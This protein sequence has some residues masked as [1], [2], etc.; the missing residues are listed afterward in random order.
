MRF[1]VLLLAVICALAPA[2]ANADEGHPDWVF[3]GEEHSDSYSPCY[4]AS[5]GYD[6]FP[7]VPADFP[8]EEVAYGE[9]RFYTQGRMF[10]APTVPIRV[11]ATCGEQVAESWTWVGGLCGEDLEPECTLHWLEISTTFTVYNPTSPADFAIQVECPSGCSTN[12]YDSGEAYTTLSL[13]A[14]PT[15]IAS[16]SWSTIKSRY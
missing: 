16:A 5:G 13:Y 10:I 14:H 8:W 4:G 1:G 11:T 6:F 12:C 3:E 15:A 7:A 9:L 2:G